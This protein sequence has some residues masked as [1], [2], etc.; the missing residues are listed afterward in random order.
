MRP[1]S[2][3]VYLTFSTC[4]ACRLH[5]ISGKTLGWG[6]ENYLGIVGRGWASPS[7]LLE[8][9]HC[10]LLARPTKSYPAKPALINHSNYSTAS[11]FQDLS[12]S[13]FTQNRAWKHAGLYFQE[14]INLAIIESV[15]QTLT[16]KGALFEQP[17]SPPSPALSQPVIS[18]TW[19]NRT[20]LFVPTE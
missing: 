11:S 9:A 2:A 1:L 5:V 10:R 19:S 14:L 18:R 3:V 20:A 8:Q 4:G 7:G 6:K 12:R 13:V 17:L 15:K 16:D